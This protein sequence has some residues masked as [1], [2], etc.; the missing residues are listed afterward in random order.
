MLWASEEEPCRDVTCL[1]S[2]G[3]EKVRNNSERVC[4]SSAVQSGIV[5]SGFTCLLWMVKTP[6]GVIL[7][8][9]WLDS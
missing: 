6:E 4:R 2:D 5:A 3:E 9:V 8:T 7:D 1:S